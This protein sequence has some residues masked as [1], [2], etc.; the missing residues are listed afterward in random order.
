MNEFIL[1]FRRDFQTDEKQPSP[2]ELQ[3]MLKPW[4]D[5]M[6]SIAAKNKQVSAG[7]RLRNEGRVVRPGKV[8]TNGP[9]TEIKEAL[10]G[11]IVVRAKDLDEAAEMAKGSP[12]LSIGGN[13]EVRAIIPKD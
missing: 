9:Y 7:N 13:V 1:L 5:W 4:E 10:G 8:I 2:E 12:V 3:A 11:F 6:G